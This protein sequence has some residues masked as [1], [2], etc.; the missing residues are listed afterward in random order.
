MVLILVLKRCV[1]QI[2]GLFMHSDEGMNV[3]CFYQG[4]TDNRITLTKLPSSTGEPETVPSWPR[5]IR[6]VDESSV[7][8]GRLQIKFREKW[9]GI[10]AN[11]Q[12]YAILL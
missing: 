11:F 3:E 1:L 2:F 10:C 9:R 5:D 4:T 12:K 6:L 7:Y 8:F